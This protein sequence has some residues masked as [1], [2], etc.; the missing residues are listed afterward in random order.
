M[1]ELR[2]LT[3]RVLWSF[4]SHWERRHLGVWSRIGLPMTLYHHLARLPG[5]L[6]RSLTRAGREVRTLHGIPLR[7]QLL[8]MIPAALRW[9]VYPRDYYLHALYLEERRHRIPLYLGPV[10]NGDSLMAALGA[11]DP[12][13][14]KRDFFRRCQ[15]GDLPTIP[16]LAECSRDRDGPVL[17]A[18]DSPH[19]EGDLV[20]K[21]ADAGAAQGIRGWKRQAG[22]GWSDGDD[23]AASRDELLS[24]LAGTP[25][26]HAVWIVQ[27]WVRTHSALSHLTTGGLCT[28]R[29]MTVLDPATREAEALFGLFKMPRGSVADNLA[30]GGIAAGVEMETGRLRQALPKMSDDLPRYVDTHPDTG[31]AIEGTKLPFWTEVL[32]LARTAH[33]VLPEVPAVAWDIGITDDGPVL[34]E[35]NRLWGCELIQATNDT[36]IGVTAYPRLMAK[37]LRAALTRRALQ[38]RL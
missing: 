15:E 33:A 6:W 28:V 14:G 10:S 21:P 13:Q 30:A 2:R 9:G 1:V 3:R 19:W 31:G 34:V 11:T 7:R 4:R 29:T 16:I 37:H 32:E 24:V 26:R 23:H 20:T 18:P 12:R 27:P 17:H 22:G 38:R 8:Q 25:G 5:E 35:A 36:P